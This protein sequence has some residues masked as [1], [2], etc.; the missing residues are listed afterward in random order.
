MKYIVPDDITLLEMICFVWKGFSTCYVLFTA[1]ANKMFNV[2][3][4]SFLRDAKETI[5]ASLP[6]GICRKA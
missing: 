2:I 1:E 6:E 4:C 3:C 5:P